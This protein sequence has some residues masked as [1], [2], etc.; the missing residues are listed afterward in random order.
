MIVY[1]N[2]L[3]SGL[4]CLAALLMGCEKKVIKESGFTKLESDD[5][6][7]EFEN[8]LTETIDNFSYDYLYNGAGVAAGDVNNDGLVDLYFV[9]NM[10]SNKLYLNEGDFSFEDVTEAAGVG[11]K[12]GWKTGVSMADVNGDGWLDIYVC[13]SGPKNYKERANQLFINNGSKDGD[14]PTFTERAK[15][16]GIDGDST[17][18]NQ[19][20]FFDYDLDGDLDLFLLNHGTEYLSSYLVALTK[21]GLRHQQFGNRLYRNDNNKFVEVTNA[22][23]IHDGWLN[24][25]LS[26]S[27]S[28]F[29][30]DGY[31]DLYVSNDF[32]ERDFFYLNKGDG[33]FEEALTKCFG[34]ISKYTMGSDVADIN[35][36]NL[37][38]LVTLDMLP[39]DNY[40]KK[41]LKGP[42]DYDRYMS[43]LE[44]GYHKQQMRNMLQ[45]NQ[46]IGQDGLPVFSEVG[47]FA[48]ISS[49]DWSWSSLFADFDH[50]GRKDLLITN[51]FLHDFTNLDFQ[52]YDVELERKKAVAAG[53]DIFSDEGRQYMV[54]WMTTIKSIGVSNYVYRNVN[55]VQFEDK[56][57]DWGLYELSVTTGAVYADL[58]NDGDLD[59]ATNN[60]NMPAGLYRNDQ[61]HK[62]AHYVKVKLQGELKNTFGI[63]SKIFVYTQ[64]QQ[65][66]AEAFP[67]RG[68]LSSVDNVLHFGLGKD[69]II[70]TLKV[71]W[72][73][74]KSTILT[75][76][77]SD[78]TIVVK[79][80]SSVSGRRAVESKNV[81]PASLLEDIT[82]QAGVDFLHRENNYVDF[83]HERLLLCKLSDQGPRM[84]AGDANGDGRQ[85]FFIGGAIG[86]SGRLYLGKAD[87]AFVASASQPWEKDKEAEDVGSVFVDVDGD[88]DEDLYVV[89]GGIEH[90]EGS[91]DL[92]DRLYINDGTGKFTRINTALPPK[93]G[94]SS[95]VIASDFDQDGDLDLFVGG[96]VVS[97]AFPQASASR[98]LRND[99]D[100]K[101]KQVKFTDI[102]PSFVREAGIVTDALWNDIDK[103]GWNDLIIVGHWMPVRV[104]KNTRGEFSEITT[105]LGL[106]KTGGL[107]N[108]IEAA[109]YDG[110]GD[111]DFIVGNLGTNG[112]LPAGTETPLQLYYGDFDK[113]GEIDPIICYYENGKEYP[114]ATRD[115]IIG[116]IP[117]LKKKFLRYEEYA[118][119]SITE[120]LTPEQLS[121]SR[122]LSVHT[123][124][125]VFLRNNGGR[126]E[127]E[128]LPE[129]VQYAPVQGIVTGQINDDGIPDALI[130]GNLY[131][132]RVEYGPFD[133]GIGTILLGTGQGE[134]RP[135]TFKERGVILRGDVR[136]ALLIND[137][138]GSD[139]CIISVNNEKPRILRVNKQNRNSK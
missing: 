122:K 112:E 88:G 36:D 13:Y 46:G 55:G 85:D 40:R 37:S 23:G 138:D 9:G 67:A 79:Q 20:T 29:N 44:K 27:V 35:N 108:T 75:G 127:V 78:T 95:C 56:T 16:Y 38:D 134:F 19:A 34:H 82:P 12:E 113:N 51:G 24:Y 84:S 49:T 115:D 42:D 83:K 18:S 52:R 26:A 32:D 101:K 66:S 31:P 5:T 121:G 45:L 93:R 11:G 17:Y 6:E 123:L 139:L 91:P 89:S 87:G 63:G 59:L 110:D 10:V 126:L 136:D 116:Q 21:Q 4:F 50:D 70:D 60:T 1:R 114:V 15:E 119:A 94:S 74:G 137:R 22:A 62:D 103:D 100:R 39:N 7:I 80:S 58:D 54:N 53:V 72:P 33:T 128:S 130:V 125:S 133:A 71:V 65:Q 8:R 61:A 64:S 43:F 28:D 96:W 102:T 131:G 76:I 98:L 135:A 73:N 92:E 124:Q 117:A 69:R 97:S 41:L 30:N 90:A 107:W 104:F 14:A 129:E 105:Q 111:D 3:P 47:Q 2:I 81:S 109:D 68:Y 77:K 132:Y 57:K 48:G 86:Q 99:Y 25:G 106:L 120:V 118:K